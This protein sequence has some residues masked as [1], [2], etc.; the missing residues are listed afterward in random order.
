[1]RHKYLFAASVALMCAT[2]SF[3]QTLNSLPSRVLGHPNPEQNS[4][5]VS[6]TPNLVEGRELFQP[7]GIALD[8]SATPPILY[9]SDTFNHRVLAW[10]NATSFSNGAFADLVI[11][12][13]SAFS[14]LPQGPAV[15]SSILV[16]GFYYPSGL[17][18]YK[19]DLYVVDG[20]NNRILRFPKPF[21]QTNTPPVPDLV[22]GQPNLTGHTAN[23]AATA[24]APLNEQGIYTAGSTVYQAGVAFDASGNLWFTDPGN[25]RVLRFPAANIPAPNVGSTTGGIRADLVIGQPSLTSTYPKSLASQTNPMLIK[26]QFGVVS[27]LGFDPA[28]RLYVVDGYGDNGVTSYGR[29][30]VFA[31]PG[32]LP[33][34]NGSADRVM[35]VVP[36]GELTTLGLTGTAATAM[37]LQTWVDQ[38]GGI[39]FLPDGSV[40][41]VDTGYSRIMVFPPYSQWASESTYYSPL[42]ASVV[43][44]GGSFL[45]VAPNNAQTATVANGTPPASA[46]TFFEP[47]AA[48]FLPA[49]NELFVA[50]TYNNRVVVMPLSSGVFASATRVLGQ[51]RSNTNSANLIEGREFQFVL[52]S[53]A[54]AGVAVDITGTT[55]HLYVSDPYNH[56][57]LGYYDARLV[58]PG[59]KADLVIG[60]PDFQTALCNYNPAASNGIGGDTSLPT[61]SSLCVPIGL[62]VDPA[63]NLYVADA[64]NGRVLRFPAPFAG[65]PKVATLE[66]ADLVLGQAGFTAQVR[67]ASN[68]TMVYPYG[69]AFSG[70]NGLVVSDATLNRVLYFPFGPSGTFTALTDNGKAATKVF[71]Q[72][73]FISKASGTGAGNFNVPMHV[74]SDGE[75]RIYVADP[76]NNRISIFPDPN[77]PY[78]PSG[79]QA[80][81]TITGLSAPRGVWINPNTD[82]IWITNTGSATCVRY[83]SFSSLYSGAPPNLTV[84]AVSSTLTLATDQIG[85]LYVADASNRVAI[86]YPAL[87]ALNGANFMTNRALAPGL[88]ASLCAP[89]SNCATQA[90]AFGSQTAANNQIP[91]PTV[92]G[93]V[94]VNFNDTPAPLFWVSPY[95][96]NFY[97]PSNAPTSGFAN[98]E[99]VQESTG[100]VLAAGLAPMSSSSPGIFAQFPQA[101]SRANGAQ[102]QAAVVNQDGSINSSNNAA[103]RGHLI[104]IYA[105]GQGVIPGLPA[106]GVPAPSSPLIVVP[107]SLTQVLIGTCLLS[108]GTGAP[109]GCPN[110]PGDVGTAGSVASDWIPFTGLAPGFVGLW[111]INAQIPMAVTP[112]AAII[113]VLFNFTPSTDPAPAF[114]T[115]VYVK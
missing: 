37:V 50:D 10:K 111:Q 104:Q 84:P 75:G 89:A 90:V 18:V 110:Q 98:V 13:N 14:T 105:T 8:T 33:S 2:S 6:F 79:M 48:A 28:G 47:V 69:L 43:G 115:V 30:L 93:D 34:G 52:G 17:T 76:G 4:N 94:Q 65:Y 24:S 100:Q 49:T 40:G 5:V 56:R 96:I 63:G 92:L 109:A 113:K 101:N 86:Y 55:P 58:T 80:A 73:D 71:G 54:D 74:S 78:T 59:K 20:G 68:S 27:A 12:Q 23:Y 99:V 32:S 29:V 91:V 64:R 72:A 114:Q 95:Q 88:I 11:G 46:S 51:D 1:M 26:N 3:C 106:D 81:W 19:G 60:Q 77:S 45:T 22:I 61:Q 70:T 16:T 102:D 15:S 41:I 25:A 66:A 7:Q 82:E 87:Q 85:A 31:T 9:V 21:S 44:Q 67:Q 42:A 62:A 53:T 57:V 103:V 39:F 38:P 97:V 35:G 83:S 36:T 112:G 107:R 108:E